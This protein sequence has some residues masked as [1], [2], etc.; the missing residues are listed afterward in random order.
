MRSRR[1]AVSGASVKYSFL[2]RFASRAQ[3]PTHLLP[4]A[5]SWE[6]GYRLLNVIRFKFSTNALFVNLAA[7]IT[8]AIIL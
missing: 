6:L 5:D 8:R 3:D 1:E 4:A 7:V 2:L